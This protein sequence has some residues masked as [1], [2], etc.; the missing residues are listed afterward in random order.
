MN[1]PCVR[2]L[3]LH[4]AFSIS[5]IPTKHA[6]S[7]LSHTIHIGQQQTT[8]WSGYNFFAAYREVPGVYSA[9]PLQTRRH[10]LAASFRGRRQDTRH[11]YVTRLHIFLHSNTSILALA[12][13]TQVYWTGVAGTAVQICTCLSLTMTTRRLQWFLAS[14]VTRLAAGD[15][16]LSSN[17]SMLY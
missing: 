12:P 4:W 9:Q 14:I 2:A 10:F 16:Q 11:N 5:I 1:F 8:P 17:S 6:L 3:H 7:Q 15:F 13:F